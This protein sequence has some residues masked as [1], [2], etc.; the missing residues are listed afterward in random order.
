MVQPIGGLSTIVASFLARM[1]GSGEPELSQRRTKDLEQF[2]RECE[3]YQMDRGTISGSS[4]DQAL[5]G[6]RRRFEDL[7][8]NSNKNANS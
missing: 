3:S 6:F 8:G 7:L 1:R 5:E 2:I 4:E